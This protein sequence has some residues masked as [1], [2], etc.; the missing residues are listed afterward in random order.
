MMR[1]MLSGTPVPLIPHKVGLT[2]PPVP[3]F[4]VPLRLCGES[5]SLQS[6][7]FGTHTLHVPRCSRHSHCGSGNGMVVAKHEGRSAQSG[8]VARIGGVWQNL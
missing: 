5:L 2:F 8:L 6:P 3:L 7:T 4:S 1:R